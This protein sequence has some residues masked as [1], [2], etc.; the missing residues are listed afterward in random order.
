MKK[1]KKKLILI[2]GVIA[3]I[4]IIIALLIIKLVSLRKNKTDLETVENIEPEQNIITENVVEID[5]NNIEENSVSNE[6]EEQ[7]AEMPQ[8]EDTEEISKEVIET[9]ES[10]E[11][12]AINIA[13][14]DWGDD[15]SVYFSLGG[16]NSEGKYIV[17]VREEE[18]TYLIST[19]IIDVNTEKFTVE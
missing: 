12:K 6:E 10:N 19:Y 16:K 17:E 1:E 13:K 11:E 18:T 2:S 14:N 15:N 3:I 9:E 4:L 7:S 8:P 5:E